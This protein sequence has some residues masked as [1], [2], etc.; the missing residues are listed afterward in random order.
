[1]EDYVW[2]VSEGKKAYTLVLRDTTGRNKTGSWWCKQAK[3]LTRPRSLKH[4]AVPQGL[5]GNLNNA[6]KLLANQQEDGD[7][8]IQNT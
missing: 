2:W 5:C 6:L 8:L 4:I 3:M 7:G 1:M